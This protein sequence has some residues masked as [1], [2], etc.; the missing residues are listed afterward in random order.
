MFPIQNEGSVVRMLARIS[1]FKSPTHIRAALEFIEDNAAAIFQY[2]TNEVRYWLNQ[3][4][5]RDKTVKLRLMASGLDLLPPAENLQFGHLLAL[6]Y[7]TKSSECLAGIKKVSGLF[8][9]INLAICHVAAFETKIENHQLIISSNIRNAKILATSENYPITAFTLFEKEL[10]TLLK[11]SAE[12][13]N[14]KLSAQ[15]C[16]SEQ[17]DDLKRVLEL[18]RIKNFRK[19]RLNTAEQFD[20]NQFDVALFK[21]QVGEYQCLIR[22]SDR[23]EKQLLGANPYRILMSEQSE[24]NN[25]VKL[26]ESYYRNVNQKKCTI[27]GMDF[28]TRNYRVTFK[29]QNPGIESCSLACQQQTK[30]FILA[31]EQKFDLDKSAACIPQHI[32]TNF[33]CITYGANVNTACTWWSYN[34]K[35]KQCYFMTED[36]QDFA[37]KVYKYY[38]FSN[39]IS[40]TTDCQPK[41]IEAEAYILIN[42]KSINAFNLCLFSPE[43]FNNIKLQSRC[44]GKHFEIARPV[45]NL[46]HQLRYFK[47]DFKAKYSLNPNVGRLKRWTAKPIMQVLKS[48][49]LSQGEMLV[50][51]LANGLG[52]TAKELLELTIGKLK[53]NGFEPKMVTNGNELEFKVDGVNFTK[54]AILFDSLNTIRQQDASHIKDKIMELSAEFFKLKNYFLKLMTNPVPTIQRTKEF[55][56]N[57]NFIFNA[58]LQ[59]DSITRHYF[60]TKENL[61]SAVKSISTLPTSLKNFGL[62]QLY[63]S[64]IFNEFDTNLCL[65]KL[66][67]T[68][69]PKRLVDNNVCMKNDQVKAFSDD[70]VMVRHIANNES[71]IIVSVRG[72]AFIEIYCQQSSKI[73]TADKLI[74]I[75]MSAQCSA[76][77]NKVQIHNGDRRQSNFEA[78]ILFQ[79]NMK[80]LT[81]LQQDW[82]AALL[83]L[84][85]LALTGLLITYIFLIKCKAKCITT[86]TENIQEEDME[87]PP[88]KKLIK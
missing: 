79:L 26:M 85:A 71:I 9:L 61:G 38:D 74:I 69:Q 46:L 33:S 86:N 43:R 28:Y 82:V 31:Q 22:F 84:A 11:A 14:Y 15:R 76:L 57:H 83:T 8:I 7:F 72:Q 30:R 2:K 27:H 64:D 16:A 60:V 50:K 1:R 3:I 39:S 41:Q 34:L 44:A 73:F 48:I 55:I 42:N 75:A 52:K 53:G 56:E 23:F 35:T 6:S 47:N 25:Y 87:Q 63:Q 21:D 29:I 62:I 13:G 17:P 49:A 59:D 58:F 5:L 77:I 66:L 51:G 4:A 40:G 45:E 70:V 88:L 20:K 54:I 37:S 78:K 19:I 32:K 18:A 65:R 24:I 10:T 12:L 80:S 67:Q 68:K 36:K 81:F